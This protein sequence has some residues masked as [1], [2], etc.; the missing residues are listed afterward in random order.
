MRM[1]AA[2]IGPILLRLGGRGEG[3]PPKPA[4]SAHRLRERLGQ[5]TLGESAFLLEVVMRRGIS[6]MEVLISMFI[7]LV[8]LMGVASIFPV[9]NHYAGKGEAY[10]RGSALADAAF[11]ELKTREILNPNQWIYPDATP[12]MTNDAFT[13]TPFP[14]GGSDD[15]PGQAFVIDPIGA[16][17]IATNN[18]P[19]TAAGNPW[20]AG[21]AL[22][23]S[24]S[25]NEWPIRRVTLPQT[26]GVKMTTAVAETIFRLHDDVTNEL[27]SETDRP[28]IQRWNANTNGTPDDPSDDTLL[29]RQYSGNYSWFATVCSATPTSPPAE[30]MAAMQPIDGGYSSAKYDVSVAVV[31]K[32]EETERVLTAEFASETELAMSGTEEELDAAFDGVRSGDWI[33]VAGVNPNGGAMLLKWYRMLSLDSENDVSGTVPVRRATLD[34]AAWPNP[35]PNPS[36]TV[37]ESYP[38]R[39]VRAILI[40]GVI[41]VAT[42]VRPLEQ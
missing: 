40:P 19:E 16:A 41:S 30:P 35:D 12:V 10:D 9:G 15:G 34:G 4:Q 1:R 8:G 36:P 33:L 31:R 27:P 2:V 37:D 39:D 14:P 38:V 42:Q 23:P 3:S 7:L 32:R 17:T 21:T 28:G 24:L 29:S 18:F 6:L 26:P 20:Q 25:G 13:M 11:A 22:L 5:C